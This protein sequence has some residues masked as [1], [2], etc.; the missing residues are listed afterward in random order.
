M[1]RLLALVILI[2]I[3][4]GDDDVVVVTIDASGFDAATIDG[5]IDA[6]DPE[7]CRGSSECEPAFSCIGPDDTSS[8]GRPGFA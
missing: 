1:N 3:G 7:G 6:G 4:C 5:G 2:T 8:D